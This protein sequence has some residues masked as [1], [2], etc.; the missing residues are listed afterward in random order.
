MIWPIY[1]VYVV[2]VAF[3]RIYKW[4]EFQVLKLLTP[5]LKRKGKELALSIGVILHCPGDSEKLTAEEEQVLLQRNKKY[6]KIIHIKVNDNLLFARWANKGTL[7]CEETYMDKTWEW[8]DNVE[9]VTE[10]STRTME[11][12]LLDLYYYQ[13]N[14]FL[15][16]LELYAFN[17]Q[18]RKRAFRVGQSHYDLGK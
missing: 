11:N 4:V 14:V 12:N 2:I 17:L 1:I 5:W 16:W 6:D 9:D 3:I 13:W 7:G 15:E 10:F 18:T 8:I